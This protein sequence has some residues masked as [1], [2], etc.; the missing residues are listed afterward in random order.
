MASIRK[1]RSAWQARVFRKG[2]PDETA[3]FKTKT[4]ALEWSRDVEAS[5]DAGRY[6]RTTAGVRTRRSTPAVLRSWML[7]K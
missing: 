3:A 5:M 7:L 1:R 4:E 2:F 6:R